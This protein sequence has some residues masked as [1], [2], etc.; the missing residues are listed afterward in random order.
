MKV[1]FLDI[2]GVVLPF[3]TSSDAQRTCTKLVN[4]LM[5]ETNA[6][7]VSS[8]WRVD[9]I[10]ASTCWKIAHLSDKWAGEYAWLNRNV[11]LDVPIIGVTPDLFVPKENDHTMPDGKRGE[12]IKMWLDH[13]SEVTFWIAIDDISEWIGDDLLHRSVITKSRVGFTEEHLK[14]A[15]ALLGIK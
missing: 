12:E 8:S 3:D 5:L 10:A 9:S 7:V 2:D 13:H 4:R 14:Q 11:G 1:V 15:I 6:L